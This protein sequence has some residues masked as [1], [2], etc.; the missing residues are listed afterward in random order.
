MTLEIDLNEE[1]G[2]LH[3]I[4]D[5]SLKLSATKDDEELVYSKSFAR[6]DDDATHGALKK[7]SQI[8][9]NL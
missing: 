3:I 2:E 5:N 8:L 6:I 9:L 1:S 4:I 7:I